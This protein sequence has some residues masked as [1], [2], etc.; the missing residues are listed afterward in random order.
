[1]AEE[2]LDDG[3]ETLAAIEALLIDSIDLRGISK[4]QL[5]GKVQIIRESLLWRVHELAQNAFE[6]LDADRFV[7]SALV[8]RAV[9]ET[10]AALVFLNTLMRRGIDQG[11]TEP[12]IAK[13]DRFL[14]NS[15]V[16]EELEDPIHVNDM[17]R[18]VEKVIPGFFENHYANLSEAAH[19]NW[20]GTFG[21]FGAF[22]KV[23]FLANFKKGGR[24]PDIQRK[25]IAMNLAAT[26]GLAKGYYEIAGGNIDAFVKA[27]E[28][29][30]VENSPAPRQT[31]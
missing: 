25:K 13:I 15:K 26:L 10:T 7:A 16:W 29:Y 27:A 5:P 23:N 19:P 3:R 31:E 18:E 8:A 14:I 4:W 11:V 9:M 21:A 28:T 17:L 12:L 1:M 30:Y 22:D 2:S 24:S 20:L 6:T